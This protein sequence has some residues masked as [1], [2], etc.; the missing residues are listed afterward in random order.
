MKKK[1][2]IGVSVSSGTLILSLI[3]LEM[4]LRFFYPQQLVLVDPSI[5]APTNTLGWKHQ[6]NV[7]TKVKT[8]SGEITFHTD[9]SGYRIDPKRYYPDTADIKILFIGDS[10]AEAMQ[11]DDDKTTPERV[12]AMLEA[13]YGKKVYSCNTGVGDWDPN[14]YLI[15]SEFELTR[16]KK[17]DLGVVFLYLGN[18]VISERKTTFPRRQSR[19]RKFK[20]TLSFMSA[21]LYPLNDYLQ[22]RSHLFIFLKRGLVNL[23][24]KLGLSGYPIADAFFK[25]KSNDR[26]WQITA[27][28]CKDIQKEFTAHKTP[29]I[30]VFIPAI[31]QV[32]PDI[33]KKFLHLFDI[34]EE[35]IYI[36]QP[37]IILGK[38]FQ[39]RR[40]EYIDVLEDFRKKSAE[41]VNL[42]GMVDQHL[43]RTGYNYLAELILPHIEHKLSLLPSSKH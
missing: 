36:D 20:K 8:P 16:G 7:N 33:L 23:R 35:R 34:A 15:Q 29:V 18:D 17:Y 13:G 9:A 4:F 21:F 28:I 41:G 5:Y 24:I 14:Q 31:Y 19:V 22:S 40:I 6:S 27:D 1:F 11:V 32:E 25:E 39:A 43:N 38:E 37:N 12:A 10:F 3:M 2:L 30:F 26:M 42:Y